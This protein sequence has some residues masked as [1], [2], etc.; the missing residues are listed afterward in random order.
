[1]ESAGSALLLIERVGLAP[2][3]ARRL[4]GHG[5][6]ASTVRIVL[7]QALVAVVV[8]AGMAPMSLDQSLAALLAGLVCVV[9]NAYF[10]WR[11]RVERSPA[12]LL[13][14]G[15]GKLALTTALMVAVFAMAK[16]APLGFF[17]AF[18]AMQLMYVAGSP[19]SGS[20]PPDRSR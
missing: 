5:S 9:P 7:Y 2:Y 16:P 8:A 17:A 20:K 18:I 10:A 19:G 4:S 3:N 14:Q 13:A 11:A 6:M 1:L 15:V 12:L